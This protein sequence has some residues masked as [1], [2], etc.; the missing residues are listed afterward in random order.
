MHRLL[1]VYLSRGSPTH[2]L[3]PPIPISSHPPSP[4]PRA[5]SKQ[6]S[7]HTASTTPPKKKATLNY[8]R[9][10]PHLR[11]PPG[12]DLSRLPRCLWTDPA[13]F[14]PGFADDLYSS[15]SQHNQ[16]YWG[17]PL[18]VSPPPPPLCVAW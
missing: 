16:I 8:N 7:T 3:N 1:L 4:P 13:D 18:P 5:N 2:R 9:P 17:I 10:P 14:Q 6:A 11:V 15:T 12:E